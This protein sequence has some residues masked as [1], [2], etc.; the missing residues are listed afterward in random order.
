MG[1]DAMQILYNYS[2]KIKDCIEKNDIQ[3]AIN[4][5]EAT[6]ETIG[7]FCI[8]GSNGEHEEIQNEFKETMELLIDKAS[9]EEKESF[10]KWLSKYIKEDD[11]FIDFK[12]EF[13]E[14]YNKYV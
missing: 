9:L 10:L 8:D 6:M 12:D 1:W 2:Y 13:G 3:E 11:E 5:F 4:I 7:E 14:I